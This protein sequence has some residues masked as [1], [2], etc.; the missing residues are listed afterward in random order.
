VTPQWTIGADGLI[1]SERFFQGDE[2]NLNAPLAGY[3]IVNVH[4]SYDI[5][6]NVQVYGLINNLFDRH[7]YVFGTYID[8]DD[9]RTFRPNIGDNHLSVMPGMP[10]AAYGGMKVKF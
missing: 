7:Y 1:T 10:F 4:T 5:T 2:S 3:E 9:F 6:R 8:P